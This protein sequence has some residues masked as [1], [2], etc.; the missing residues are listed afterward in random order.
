M[1]AAKQKPDYK[2]ENQH[3]APY[4]GNLQQ[5]KKYDNFC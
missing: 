1:L 5:N 4:K 2:K 3:P